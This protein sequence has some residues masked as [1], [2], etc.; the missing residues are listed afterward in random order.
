MRG[1]KHFVVSVRFAHSYARLNRSA[2]T[3]PPLAALRPGPVFFSIS[4]VHSHSSTHYQ[5]RSIQLLGPVYSQYLRLHSAQHLASSHTDTV[6][7]FL[8]IPSTT[9]LNPCPQICAYNIGQILYFSSLGS[10]L[11][12][13]VY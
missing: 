5:S 12:F 10:Q 2:N 13:T 9:T 8:H 4:C 1:A 3:S 6:M 11:S 7:K